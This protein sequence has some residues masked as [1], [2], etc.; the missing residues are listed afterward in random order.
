MRTILLD[1]RETTVNL[2]GRVDW[3]LANAGGHAFCRVHYAPDLLRK[4]TRRLGGV[5]SIERFNLLNDAW[6]GVL[7]GSIA[8]TDYLDLT[9]QFRNERN[10]NVWAVLA[11]S[12]E[13]L[14]RVITPAERP[15]LETLVRNRVGL[16]VEQ[17][18]WSP[19]PDENELTQQLRGDLLRLIGTLGNDPAIQAKARALYSR[20]RDDPSAVDPDVVAALVAILAHA[21]GEAEY[22]EFFGAFRA[23]RTPQEEQRYL[24]AL[25][26]F[27]QPELIEQTLERTINGE[28]RTQ[29]AP[30]LVRSL[31]TSVYG[32]ERAWRFVRVNWETMERRYPAKSGLRRMFE[33]I[34]GLATPELEADVHEFFRSRNIVLGGKTLEQ[35]LERLH[36]AV[37]FRERESASLTA[38][39][40]RQRP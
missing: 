29:D 36:V 33:G 38:Y 39:L 4:L 11:G 17:L 7:A 5:G 13:Y 31:L 21:G 14:N 10:K 26:G 6:A 32:R 15:G 30:F 18:G 2:P 12:F 3:A 16:L 20:Y 23:A 9:E 1:G 34:T 37:V 40:L 22:A 28:V 24:Y 35:Y 19:E 27:R 8:V 25:A